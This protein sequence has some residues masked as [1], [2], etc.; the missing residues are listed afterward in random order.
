MSYFI[1]VHIKK[2]LIAFK[3]IVSYFIRKS[4]YILTPIIQQI[5]LKKGTS[6]PEKR[7]K[8]Q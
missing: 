2:F 6:P 4:G 5:L 8:K 7:K 3:F 1:N